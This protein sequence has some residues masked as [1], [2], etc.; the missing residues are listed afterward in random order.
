MKKIFIHGIV[1][2]ILAALASLIYSNLYQ[3]TLG[4]AFDKV[5]N[6]A[7]I[8]GSSIFGCVLMTI[9][10]LL[11]YK[12]KK[13]NLRGIL[14]IIITV[15]S[16]ASIVGPISMSLPLDIEAPE[17]FPGLVVPMHFFPALAFFAIEPF[18]RQKDRN[19]DLIK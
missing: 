17:M 3:S 8:V 1:A 16:F 18:F 5:I 11:L 19:I 10:Y 12:F 2:G 14:N 4:T 6:T 7:S 13:E 9:G 15:L